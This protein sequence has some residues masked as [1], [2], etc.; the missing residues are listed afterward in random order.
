[1]EVLLL[2]DIAGVGR[3]N[4]IVSVRDGF[5]LNFLLPQRKGL[6]A[7]PTVRKRYAEEIKRRAEERARE[8]EFRTSVAQALA[9]KVLTFT[10]KV[11]K[12][13]KLYASVSPR[14]VAGA[15]KDQLSLDVPQDA[16]H[17]REPIKATGRFDVSVKMGEAE[18]TVTVEV[19]AE[20]G[21]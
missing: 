5:A 8:Q 16:V 11:T 10:R 2:T 14:D 12:T 4:E 15:L 1:M 17:V 7:T 9:G 3:R 21:R 13:G 19:K 20:G 18:G 6:V